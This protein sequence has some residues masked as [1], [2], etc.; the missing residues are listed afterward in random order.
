M[1]GVPDPS[2]R[3]G[4]RLVADALAAASASGVGFVVVLGDP[5][6]YRRFGFEAASGWG[7][8]DPYRGGSAFQVVELMAGSL[9]RRGGLVRYAPEFSLVAD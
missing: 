4:G 9:A 5:D 6:Y 1:C 7:L 3:I 8:S 2:I